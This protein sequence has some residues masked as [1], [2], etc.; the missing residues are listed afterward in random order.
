MRKQL[1]QIMDR[2]KLDM[3]SAGRSYIKIQK[4]IC[5]GFFFHAARK[6]PQEVLVLSISIV[7]PLLAPTAPDVVCQ[8]SLKARLDAQ[9]GSC[10]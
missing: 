1:L 6:D 7:S 2:Y 5:S 8:A 9:T 4:A 10:K 3:V